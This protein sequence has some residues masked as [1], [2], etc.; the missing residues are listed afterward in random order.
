M[1]RLFVFGVV[2]FH[3]CLRLFTYDTLQVDDAEAVNYSQKFLWG[4]GLDQ[5]PLYFWMLHLVYLLFGP[6]FTGTFLLKYALLGLTVFFAFRLSRHLFPKDQGLR[7][8]AMA[9]LLLLPMFAWQVHHAFTHSILLGVAVLMTLDALLRLEKGPYL[10]FGF[11]LSVG[12]LAKYSFALFLLPIL[13]AALS[14]PHYRRALLDRRIL[15][16]LSVVLLCCAPHFVYLFQEWGT[17]GKIVDQKLQVQ[18]QGG[19]ALFIR[20][21]R[22]IYHSAG[23]MILLYVWAF[24]GIL[25]RRRQVDLPEQRVTDAEGTVHGFE[26][27]AFDKHRMLNGLDDIAVTL[28]YAADIARFEETQ[29][30]RQDWL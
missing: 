8:C 7:S 12:L 13:L 19:V 18:S 23:W 15:I 28:E 16:T 5:P 10:Y 11:A 14:I 22:A 20:A 24:P 29:A 21:L 6:S 17:V 26:I 9:S 1:V 30:G 4:Y 2:L 3:L 25:H 27:A